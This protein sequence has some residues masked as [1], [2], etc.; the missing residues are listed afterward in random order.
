MKPVIQTTPSLLPIDDLDKAIV[1]LSARI[2]AATY[3]LLVLIRQFDERA[4]WLRWGLGNCAEWLHWRCDL[5]MNAARE[6]VRVAHSIKT[7]PAVAAAF[8]SGELSY[9]KVRAMT[10]VV[11]PHNE[12]DFVTFALQT[13]TARVEER[14]RELRC[15]RADSTESANRAF[16]NRSLRVR[17]NP[18]NGMMTITVDLPIEVGDL[19]E[20]ALDKAR[21][22]S[23]TS[24]EFVYESWSARQADALLEVANAYL[25]PNVCSSAA[26]S[27][28]YLVTVHVDQS[29]LATGDG[30][31]SLPVESVKRMCCDGNAVVL[32]EDDCG[33]ALSIGRKTRTVPTA[34]KRALKA[35]DRGCTF[36]GCR[37]ERFVDA[38]H[39]RHWSAGGETSL[40]NLMLLCSRHHKLV[41][42]GGFEIERDYQNRWFFKRPDGR[43]V[44]DCGYSRLDMSDDDIGEFSELFNNPPAGGL[45]TEAKNFVSEPGPPSYWH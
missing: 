4:G 22:D 33:E 42:E 45:L 38:H 20:K 10:R 18:E 43:A 21:D 7:L 15:G 26:T 29:A 14:C 9:S 40:D 41:H 32:V 35:R 36:P 1:G 5:S 39:V 30:R 28:Q 31:S 24:G 8:S 16:A 17:R 37:H 25:A 23:A 11:G 13:T 44:P 34:I 6:K 3:E 19:V 27:D 2:N 12:E